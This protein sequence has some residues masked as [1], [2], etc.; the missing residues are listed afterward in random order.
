MRFVSGN[1]ARAALRQPANG[2]VEATFECSRPERLLLT[3][4]DS[5]G[6]PLTAPAGKNQAC[7]GLLGD[8]V[9]DVSQLQEGAPLPTRYH[10]RHN[11]TISFSSIVVDEFRKEIGRASCRERV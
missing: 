10:L 3:P 2:T 4:V 6:R 7:G 8:I 9:D 1:L 11:R 5:E